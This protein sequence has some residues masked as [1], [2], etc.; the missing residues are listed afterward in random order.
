M[1]TISVSSLLLGACQ[2]TK[3]FKPTIANPSKS[4]EAKL[5]AVL[6][7]LDLID[8]QLLSDLPEAEVDRR[9]SRLLDS[10]TAQLSNRGVTVETLS[11]L[12]SDNIDVDALL[13]RYLVGAFSSEA[14]GGPQFQDYVHLNEIAVLAEVGAPIPNGWTSWA[15]PGA[16]HLINI[17]NIKGY[18]EPFPIAFANAITDHE[19]PLHT[20]L[21]CIFIFS[22]SLPVLETSTPVALS[23]SNIEGLIYQRTPLFCE[24]DSGDYKSRSGYY[25]PKAVPASEIENII[26]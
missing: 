9:V 21:K 22:P 15:G 17:H 19:Q 26:R 8:I 24:D 12:R 13:R 16:F 11:E 14:L 3:S 18:S 7:R 4:D 2:Q 1:F 20:G 25:T 6:E 10:Y 23:Q 5:R